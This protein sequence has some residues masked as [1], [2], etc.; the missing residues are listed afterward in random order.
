MKD[1]YFKVY[2]SELAIQ[3]NFRYLSGTVGDL[4][5]KLTKLNNWH[6]LS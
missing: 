5:K 4:N 1:E 3:R 6:S 2:L